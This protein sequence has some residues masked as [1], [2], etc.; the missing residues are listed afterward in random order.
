M[1]IILDRLEQEVGQ[2]G[3]EEWRPMLRYV[4]EL[5][6]RSIRMPQFP[7]TTPWEEIG[8]GYTNS[9]A[10]GHWDIVHSVLDSLPQEPEHARN[11]L[12]HV[13]AIQQP[14]GLLPGA[15]WMKCDP[16]EWNLKGYPPVWVYAVEEYCRQQQDYRFA[17]E[18]F[19]PLCRNIKWY[20]RNRRGED[21]GFFYTYDNCWE[22]GIDEGIRFDH[23]LPDR[24]TAVDAVSHVFW[25][26]DC[27]ARWAEM[28]GHSARKEYRDKAEALRTL[29]QTRLFDTETGFF[30]DIWSVGNPA[31]RCLSFEGMWPVVVGAAT[32]EQ[33][34]RVIDENLLNPQR[35]FTVHPLSTVAVDDPRFEP[36]MWRGP[37]WNSMTYWAA[38]GCVGYR[39]PDAARKLLERALDASL[40][41]F[42]RTGTIWEFY[43]ALGH[44]PEKLHRKPNYD[45]PCRDYLGHNPLIAMARLWQQC[46]R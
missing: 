2:L 38:L 20:E 36:R 25:L 18:C 37:A 41:Q 45:Q 39:R 23:G 16:P 1:K 10:F 43:D 17:A 26:Y 24:Q 40:A 46:C 13:L 19:E 44:E 12:R 42:R 27:A 29:I 30:H 21:G 31:L 14:N 5:H 15:V 7:F 9:P 28:F 33:A 11:Q 8:P 34:N 4:A 22:S 35:F 32:T 6:G 3:R